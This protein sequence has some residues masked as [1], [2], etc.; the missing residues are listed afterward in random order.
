[1]S[2]ST[3]IGQHSVSSLID[4]LCDPAEVQT[5]RSV[6]LIEPENS[7]KLYSGPVIEPAITC[8][9]V[10]MTK[11]PTDHSAR[12]AVGKSATGIMAASSSTYSVVSPIHI[13]VSP[14]IKKSESLT[15]TSKISSNSHPVPISIPRTLCV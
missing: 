4:R 12:S 3:S 9:G 14:M 8:A 10:G 13:W 1:M 5:M 6:S 11:P 7:A 15:V 2:T